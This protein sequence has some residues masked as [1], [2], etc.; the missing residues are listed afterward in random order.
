MFETAGVRFPEEN[1]KVWSPDPVIRSPLKVATPP[2]L[3]VAVRFPL[4]VPVPE[5]RET[6]IT[7]PAS[8]TLPPAF[9]IRT[10]GCCVKS[11]PLVAKADG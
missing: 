10:L 4:S 2:P 9:R 11:T 5:A 1:R 6:V 8:V 3:V 7:I